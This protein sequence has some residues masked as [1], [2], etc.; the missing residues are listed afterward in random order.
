VQRDYVI[1]EVPYHRLD[2]A[3]DVLARAFESD[4]LVARF[5][6]T[7]LPDR[8]NALR[9][10][11]KASCLTRLAQQHPLLG[12]V[13]DNKIVAVATVKAP[14]SPAETESVKRA[15]AKVA[16]AIGPENLKRADEFVALREK[17]K[18]PRLHHYLVSMGVDPRFQ[19]MGFGS[20]LLEAVVEAAKND[21]TSTGVMLET[22]TPLFYERRGFKAVGTEKLDGLDLTYMYCGVR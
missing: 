21:N 19:N 12:V 18:Q 10:L 22:L 16:E 7:D 8:D 1:A 15:W 3:A 9:T 4:P 14:Y 20:V 6:P 2:E 11:M 17:H 5:V 13:W